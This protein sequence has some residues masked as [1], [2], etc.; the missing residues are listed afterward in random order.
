MTDWLGDD[1]GPVLGR[2]LRMFLAGEEAST[3]LEWRQVQTNPQEAQ[4][5]RL[6][7]PNR[8]NRRPSAAAN[9]CRENG[10]VVI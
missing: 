6:N 9:R 10:L 2:G 5:R 8:R 4:A 3:L 7:R 1:D